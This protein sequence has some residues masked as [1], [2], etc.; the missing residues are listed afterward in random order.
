M[1]AARRSDA[2]E[3]TRNCDILPSRSAWEKNQLEQEAEPGFNAEKLGSVEA[4][5]F[6]PVRLLDKNTGFS[7]G[8]V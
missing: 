5:A 8:N 7:T 6:R 4:P 1:S 2:T 3:R